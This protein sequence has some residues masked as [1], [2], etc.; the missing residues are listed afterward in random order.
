MDFVFPSL[1]GEHQ[2]DN[3]STAISTILSLENKLFTEKIINKGLLET[4]WPARMQKLNDGKLSSIMGNSFEIWLDGGHNLEASNILKKKI[5]MWKTDNVFLIMGMMIGKNPVGFLRKIIQEI[6]SIF[7]LPISDH[8]YIQPYEI[9]DQIIAKLQAKSEV[10]CSLD[11]KEALKTIKKK[12]SSGKIIICGSLYLAGEV[13]KEDG[14][15]I[16]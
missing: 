12:H 3:A 5:N 7:L 2:I 6:S 16:R 14:F 15:I 11:I 8:Q 10:F 4:N 9:K 13:L 1:E